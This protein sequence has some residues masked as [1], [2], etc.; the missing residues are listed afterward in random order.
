[1]VPETMSQLRMRS[2]V[3]IASFH[4]RRKFSKFAPHRDGS[5]TDFAMHMEGNLEDF[6]PRMEQQ[7]IFRDQI[8]AKIAI[9][10]LSKIIFNSPGVAGAVL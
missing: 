1:M 7:H 5:N 4:V 6:A 2:K 3:C 9:Y 8:I 10:Q